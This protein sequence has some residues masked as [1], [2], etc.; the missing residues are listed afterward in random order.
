MIRNY[1]KIAWRNLL[2]NKGLS[3]INIFGLAI[4]MAFAILIG[5]WIQFE[6]SFDS[7]QKNR[8]RIAIVMKNTLFNNEKNTRES[9]PLPLYAQLKTNYPEVKRATRLDWG[10]EHS[11]MVGN[12]RFKKQ[13]N[14]V[15]PDF[16]EIFTFPVIKGDALSPLKDPNSIVLT[17]SLASTLF[18]TEN[19]IGKTIRLDNKFTVHV[20]AIINDVPDNSSIEFEFLAPY[21]FKEQ[22]E[23]FVKNNLNNW[24]N[25]SLMTMV[26]LKEGVSMEGFSRKLGPLAV[27]K[28]KNLKNQSFILHPMGKW[29]LYA[30]FKNWVNTGG[31]IAYVRLFGIIGIFVLLIACINF[32]NLSTARSE[33]RAREVGI[34]K[35]IGSQRLQLIV[36]FLSE[37]ML[38]SF[39][40]FLL[41]L[42]LVQ[43]I[44]PY[45]K[46]LG[47]EHVVFDFNNI[48]LLFSV[49][50]VCIISGVIAGSY[51]ALY[52][53]SFVPV[54]VLKGLFKQG[55]GAVVFR[56]VLVVSQFTISIGLIISTVIVFRQIQH[57]QK[58]SLG[59]NPDNLITVSST[60]DL[61]KNFVSVKQDLL[62][63]GFIESV[64]KA[65]SPMT[66]VYHTW[67]D[68]SWDGKPTGEDMSMDVVMTEWDYEKTAGLKF[69]QGRA[70]SRANA[71]DSNAVIL[72]ET[73]LKTIGYKD[74]IGKTMKLGKQPLTI[75]GIIEDVLMEE[76]FKPV[77]PTAILFNTNNI[78][79]F[80]VRLKASAD[81]TSTLTAMQSIFEKYNPSLPFEYRFADEEFGKKFTTEKQ[82]GKL[83]G[84]FAGLAI[85]ISCLG[86]F[87][88]AA[89]M[90]ERRIKE[91]GIRKVLGASVGNLWFLLSKEF[92]L[93][94][95]LACL[96]ASPL[97]YWLM[98]DWLQ[99]YDYRITINAWIFVVAGIM[100][101]LIALFTVSAQ[102]IR[103]AVTNPVKSL[104]TE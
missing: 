79:E 53:S 92:V 78:N 36:Q 41:S 91:I 89:F 25:N 70:F 21:A 35:A 17:E 45:L 98:G 96:I 58:R 88:L 57:A 72:N 65:S 50:G 104:R 63:T 18:G 19:P 75:V 86:L 69:L 15:D 82:V 3:F 101:V 8:D 76:P 12:S 99:G 102:A 26:E 7:F 48:S 1:F 23:Q 9:V 27:A 22:N 34:R 32:M 37:S 29:H 95:L 20:T 84:I 13:G 30:E 5:L 80:L 87:G 73:A 33:N 31:R 44:L 10:D 71:G 28:N 62:N 38:T 97:A 4:G 39:I 2:K 85:F 47:F 52:L 64:S 54:K 6:I 16:M 51:P 100:A 93:L 103:A 81:V 14:Y 60:D 42:G 68:F 74:P 67:S 49:L 61:I 11:L 77:S 90:A 94:V 46:D 24:S 83:S 40:A 56:R 59:Y 66:D 43:L 55:R